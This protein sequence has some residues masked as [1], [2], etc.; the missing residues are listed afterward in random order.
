MYLFIFTSPSPRL[1][2]YSFTD[3]WV[4]VL[5]YSDSFSWGSILWVYVSALVSRRAAPVNLFPACTLHGNLTVMFS[6][7]TLWGGKPRENPTQLKV[8]IVTSYPGYCE[9]R[10]TV[11]RAVTTAHLKH[12]HR[13]V[14]GGQKINH[15]PRR[16]TW[17]GLGMKE[18]LGEITDHENS[19]SYDE[20]VKD[21]R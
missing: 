8:T 1:F 16:T 17:S 7:N 12:S 18:L 6:V 2:S 3:F 21:L 10:R 9:Q 19:R 20:A 5:P 4:F 15:Q 13:D 14:T 11:S